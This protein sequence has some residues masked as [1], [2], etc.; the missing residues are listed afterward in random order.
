MRTG[1][2]PARAQGRGAGSAQDGFEPPACRSSAGGTPGPL[3]PA[4]PPRASSPF[5]LFP[6]S[7]SSLIGA[8]LLVCLAQ[9]RPARV[10]GPASAQTPGPSPPV[11]ALDLPCEAEPPSP[12]PTSPALGAPGTRGRDGPRST[13]PWVPGAVAALGTGAPL[14]RREPGRGPASGF[15]AAHGPSPR[16]GP[17]VPLLPSR[18]ARPLLAPRVR[19]RSAPPAQRSG[20]P[21]AGLAPTCRG[22]EGRSWRG[23]R[24]AGEEGRRGW[25]RGRGVVFE[26]Q[27]ERGRR[28]EP[29]RARS[30]RVR[31]VRP[32]GG[33]VLGGRGRGERRGSPGRLAGPASRGR[34]SLVHSARLRPSSGASPLHQTNQPTRPT[35]PL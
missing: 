14:P 26:R 33:G 10:G 19:A 22:G 25:G 15:K 8:P 18:R 35:P 5:S 20:A 29:R 11:R 23:T 27:G 12:D 6:S 32:V 34:S 30:G 28:R 1:P 4:F 31:R 16:S 9:G 2:G 24:G 21:S 13:A 17:R 3:G 7:L